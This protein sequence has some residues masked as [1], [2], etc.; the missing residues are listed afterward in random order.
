MNLKK[1]SPERRFMADSLLKDIEEKLL[2]DSFDDSKD[3]VL[4]YLTSM[5]TTLAVSNDDVLKELV[6]TQKYLIEKRA[7]AA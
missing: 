2:A 7:E 5:I 6:D 1:Y 3:Y 4:G